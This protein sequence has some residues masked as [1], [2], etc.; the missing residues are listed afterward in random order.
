MNPNNKRSPVPDPEPS[1]GSS[2]R[3]SQS[4]VEHCNSPEPG[5]DFA[6]MS[7]ESLRSSFSDLG[8]DTDKLPKPVMPDKVGIS[9]GEKKKD[10]DDGC[11][12][13]KDIDT[14]SLKSVEIVI[15]DLKESKA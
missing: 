9:E 15:E 2:Y 4:P 7:L 5:K 6:F 13:E 1:L 11:D 10:M 12:F 8:V 3:A 14:D